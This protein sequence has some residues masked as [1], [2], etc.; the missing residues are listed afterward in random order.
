MG[1]AVETTQDFVELIARDCW[2][3]EATTM[4]TVDELEDFIAQLQRARVRMVE[5]IDARDMA[6]YKGQV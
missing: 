3:N 6:K 1:I 2:G 5:W 4:Y